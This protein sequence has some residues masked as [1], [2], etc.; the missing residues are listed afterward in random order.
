MPSRSRQRL[1]SGYAQLRPDLGAFLRR[2]RKEHELKQQSVAD[3]IGLSRENLSRIEC[4]HSWPGYDTLLGLMMIFSLD[5]PQIAVEGNT[6][7]V[8]RPFQDSRRA[9]SRLRLGSCLR[10]GRQS[11]GLSLKGLAERCGM[12]AAQLS[13]IERGEASRS[14]A[15]EDDPADAGWPKDDRCERFVH[16]ELRRLAG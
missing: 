2:E 12:S 10:E 1:P 5:W 14:R 3:D 15:F 9:L 7:R 13:R 8:P 16:L 11:E 6:D 4:G